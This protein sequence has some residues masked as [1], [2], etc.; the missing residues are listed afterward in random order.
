MGLLRQ[1]HHNI[2]IDLIGAGQT[3]FSIDD[4]LA[5]ATGAIPATGSI[6]QPGSSQQLVQIIPRLTI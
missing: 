2:A 4:H 6:K 5:F 1:Q 3:F